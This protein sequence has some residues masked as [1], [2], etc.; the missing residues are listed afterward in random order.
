[1]SRARSH[2]MTVRPGTESPEVVP[3]WSGAA[4]TIPRSAS[5]TAIQPSPTA[6]PPDPCDIST[7]GA[8]PGSGGAP[9]W[10]STPTNMA[11]RPMASGGVPSSA[12]YQR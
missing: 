9:G 11:L 2:G 7:T 4:T 3:G 6:L 8:G 1:M 10:T 12:G 5:A